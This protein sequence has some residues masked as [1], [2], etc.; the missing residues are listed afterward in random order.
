MIK[1]EKLSK[2]YGSLTVL[3]EINAD[4]KQG[5]VISIIGPSG[6]GK[7]TFLRCINLLEQPTGGSISIDGINLLDK[8]TNVPKM[9]QKMGM[10]FQSFNIFAHL[11]VLENLT[12]GPI[13]LLNMPKEEAEEQAREFL[14]MVGLAEKENYFADE[15]S[16][17]Q[18]Q[19]IAIARCLS[20]KP[21]IILFD[22]P[23]SALDP[24]MVSEVLAVIRRL[25]KNG[26][27]MLIVTHEMDF[28]RDVSSRIFYMDEGIIYEEG[29]PQTIFSN[30]QKEK[31]K[32]FINR[33][34]SMNYSINSANYD[35]YEMNA[36]IE[37]FCD[38][39]ILGKKMTNNTVL[40][41]EELLSIFSRSALSY[42]IQI[43]LEYSEKVHSLEIH[44]SYQGKSLNLLEST[45][46]DDELSVNI[47]NNLSENT[48][49]Q[50]DHDINHLKISLKN[51]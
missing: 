3:K 33:I 47:V 38:K 43:T 1:V 36:E 26:M 10:V 13:K 17:G 22:E 11:T 42:N 44:F 7:S 15:L 18:K 8:D 14:K 41:I 48:D 39:H 32:A 4:I 25:A 2:I 46:E 34:R 6:T 20:M 27:T 37:M 29:S 30:P 12:I 16:G 31:T 5:E 19:R 21:E 45:L 40:I 24:T 9:R 28:A 50:F 23:T 51:K 35:L 49:Y